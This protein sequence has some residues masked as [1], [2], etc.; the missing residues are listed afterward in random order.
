M[1]GKMPMKW[2]TRERP[3]IDRIACPWL[4]LR[5]IDKEPEFLFVPSDK[6]VSMAAETGAIPYD[7]PDV[8]LSHDGPLCSF[9]AFLR[10]YRLSDPALHHMA[11]IIRGA[12]TGHPELTLQSGG[13]LAIS[14][15]LSH[16]FPDDHQMLR[17][18]LVMY[19]A[20]YSWARALQRETHGWP[21]A[22]AAQQTAT[23]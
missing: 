21:P 1:E 5:Y 3:K 18:G 7:I 17:H 9:D 2:I 14:L 15:G 22:A 19:D 4:I 11:E 10:K 20:L 8:E 6:V 16:N 23:S 12:D 13:L